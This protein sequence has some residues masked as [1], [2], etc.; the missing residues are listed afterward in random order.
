MPITQLAKGNS[1]ENNYEWKSKPMQLAQVDD[2]LANI[3]IL[4]SMKWRERIPLNHLLISQTKHAC[5]QS[6]SDET[7][8]PKRNTWL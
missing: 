4:I 7:F 1:V 6:F 5:L 3:N 8:E 2:M